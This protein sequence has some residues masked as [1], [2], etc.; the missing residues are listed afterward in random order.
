MPGEGSVFQR[1]SDKLWVA[2]VSKGPRG[3][4]IIHRRYARSRTEAR[5]ALA[6]LKVDLA[7]SVIRPSTPVGDYLERWANEA[8]D[9]RDTTRSGYK[10]VIATHLRPTIGHIPLAELTPMHVE[11]MLSEFTGR[12]APKTARN[13]HVVLRRALGQAVRGGLIP[14]NVAARE[15]VDAPKVP[16]VDPRSLTR[17]EVRRFLE[18]CRG[19]RLEA[20]FVV[21]LG[22]GLRQGELLGLEWQDIGETHLSVRQELVRRN[23]VYDVAPPKTERSKRSVPLAPHVKAALEAHR[24]RV[25]AAGFVTIETGPVFTNL[26]GG[27]LSGSW[28]THHF[29]ELLAKAGIPRLPFKNLRTTFGSRLAE[30]GVSDRV[31]ADLMGHSRTAT[32]Q[33]HYISTSPTAAVDA[34]ER[35]VG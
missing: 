7:A 24:E 34:I 2:Q 17:D 19:D 5:E 20:L 31:I 21:A 18:A 9:I 12:M 23:G 27:D 8:R 14:R 29:Y 28:L 16:N 30:S 3:D 26:S 11:T 35:L 15:F 4:R 13:A 25:K 1:K 10:A 22:T 32:T 6:Q 33:R